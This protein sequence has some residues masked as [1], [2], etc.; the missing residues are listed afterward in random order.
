MH[1]C[2]GLF[3]EFGNGLWDG[4]WMDF[5]RTFGAALLPF[6]FRPLTAAKAAESSR[7]ER[8]AGMLPR[9][10]GSPMQEGLPLLL[11]EGRRSG[12][13]VVASSRPESMQ[14]AVPVNICKNYRIVYSV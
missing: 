8:A 13:P 7:L 6:H 9:P 12:Q 10:G 2:C 14:Q 11:P 3:G 5:V 4:F 1:F